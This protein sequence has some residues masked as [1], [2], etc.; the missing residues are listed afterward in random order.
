[1]FDFYPEDDVAFAKAIADAK[2]DGHVGHALTVAD[3]PGS[4]LKGHDPDTPPK[5]GEAPTPKM[6]EAV[7]SAAT[8]LGKAQIAA[9]DAPQDQVSAV[10]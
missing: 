5:K 3:Q 8:G 7:V 2:A 1:V 6:L 9:F 4:T 10:A